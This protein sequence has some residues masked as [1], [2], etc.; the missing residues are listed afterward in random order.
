MRPT[1]V[2]ALILAGLPVAALAQTSYSNAAVAGQ[3]PVLRE[4]VRMCLERGDSLADR[5]AYLDQEK[6]AVDSDA[7]EI[8]REGAR[9]A[10]ELRRLPAT[11]AAGVAAYNARTAAHNRRV[12]A[13]NRRVADMN[14]AV[15]MLNGDSAD[16]M[17]YC[18]VR[19]FRWR[20]DVMTGEGALR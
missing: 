13:Q 18:N 17:A 11:D 15:S 2:F 1:T 5:K 14:T 8:A 6:F 7:A 16:M 19:T 10:D 3:P 12:A 9:L 4:G 20:D